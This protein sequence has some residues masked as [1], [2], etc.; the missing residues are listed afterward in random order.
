MGQTLTIEH[1]EQGKLILKM[2]E[3]SSW[4]QV[5]EQLGQEKVIEQLRQT[6]ATLDDEDVTG[7]LFSMSKFIPGVPFEKDD[8]DAQPR[9]P[10][11]VRGANQ[12]TF[13]SVG[14]FDLKGLNHFH[15]AI[16]DDQLR[17]GVFNETFFDH[18]LF[19][20]GPVASL[21]MQWIETE[22]ASFQVRIPW[23]LII[24]PE[25]QSDFGGGS[26]HELVAEGLRTSLQQ[27]HAAGV[28]AEIRFDPFMEQQPQKARLTLP[29]KVLDPEKGSAGERD[30]IGLGAH[31]DETGFG[32]SHFE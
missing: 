17:E 18:A 6:V 10:R 21:A 28:S 27:L 24:E 15:F 20:A 30:R 16:A 5:I 19:P 13:L 2:V 4:E 8:L 3:D 1:S 32:D 9:L 23:Y 31:F 29:W 12:W 22:L 25:G 11:L 14:K 26:P 7:S